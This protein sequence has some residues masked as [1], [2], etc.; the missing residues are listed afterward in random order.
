MSESHVDESDGQRTDRLQIIAAVILGL[1]ATLTALAVFNSS[2]R[3]GESLKDYTASTRELSEANF[4]WSKGNDVYAADFALFVEWA[5]A[6]YAGDPLADYFFELM[7]PTLQDTIVWWGDENN[8]EIDPFADVADNPYT[9]EDYVEAQAREDTANALFQSAADANER[10]DRFS[11]ATVFFALT[12]FF[13]GI[14]TLFRSRSVTMGLLAGSTVT[15]AI[16]S[17]ILITSF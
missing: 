9:N 8:P 3:D 12:L 7:R 16:G 14:A 4:Y 11:L 5:K 1:A 17:V 15:L 2:L 10:G 13:G 6:D